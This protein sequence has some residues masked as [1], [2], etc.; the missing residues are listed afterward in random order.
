MR[1]LLFALLF[2]LPVST[3]SS[4]GA[5][6]MQLEDSTGECEKQSFDI[7]LNEQN[8]RDIHK[9]LDIELH[10]SSNSEI[11]IPNDPREVFKGKSSS[12][13]QHWMQAVGK[14]SLPNFEDPS[15]KKSCSAS[16]V[17]E[18]SQDDAN[19]I[20]TAAHCLKHWMKGTQSNQDGSI[21]FTTL[22]GSEVSRSFKASDIIY[23]NYSDNDVAVI[24]LNQP[25]KKD[26][27]K[28]LIVANQ[29]VGHIL[30]ANESAKMVNAAYFND[31]TIGDRGK[32]LTHQEC[33]MAGRTFNK[34]YLST[35]C[36]SYGGGSGSPLVMAVDRPDAKQQSEGMEY[37][38]V[39][40][41]VGAGRDG[42]YLAQFA[43]H[44]KYVRDLVMGIRNNRP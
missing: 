16:L 38:F 11:T 43:G 26:V 20:V 39:G 27:I 19:V 21:T 3:F 1:T 2:L 28:P 17:A 24:K 4:T 13:D 23:Q 36:I 14:M 9:P 37:L 6:F 25:I 5:S 44:E 18:R 7:P 35:T 33:K 10:S 40:S 41:L 30:S 34:N 15:K 8:I 12:S 29:K 32:N 42:H 22:E 31:I